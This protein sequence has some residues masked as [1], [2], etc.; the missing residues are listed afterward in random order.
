MT[1]FL[2]SRSGVGFIFLDSLLLKPS[3]LA[4]RSLS[5]RDAEYTFLV[6]RVPYK[7]KP[8]PDHQELG[9]IR[10]RLARPDSLVKTDI[11]Q[12]ELVI[13]GG[14]TVMPGICRNGT[15]LDDWTAQQIF[16]IDVDNDDDMR[17][18]GYELLDPLDALERAF[19]MCLDPLFLYFSHRATVEPW[20]PRYRLVFALEEPIGKEQA[21][22]VGSTLLSVFPEADPSSCQLNRMFL[23]PGGEVWPCWQCL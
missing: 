21:L 7:G 4:V 2:P 20:N 14:Y 6:D 10:N 3:T 5:P 16:F 22:L 1:S 13:R 8:K 18:R 23:S 19:D 12:L 11:E 15:K 17:K 9:A